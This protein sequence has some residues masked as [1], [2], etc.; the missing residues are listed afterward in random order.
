[1]TAVSK[2][3]LG[4][5]VGVHGIRGEVK[6]KSFTENE[7]NLT[8]YGLLSDESGSR[9]FELKIV[10]HSKELL[11]V[12]IK[13][14][15]DRNTAETLIGVGLY[16][17]RTKLPS[18]QEEEYYHADL[19]G[20]MALNSAGEKIGT[21]NAIYNFGAGDLIEIRTRDN[22]LEM[23]PF[24]KEY[25]PDVNLKEGHIIVAMMQFA[26]EDEEDGGEN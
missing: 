19:I 13:G 18:T 1:M 4:A 26:T 25:I 6:V 7:N 9:Q 17:E 16:V 14:V 24:T 12:K 5:I 2:V 10:G 11:R 8:H 3:C 22:K 20:L 21:V 15:D 23:L